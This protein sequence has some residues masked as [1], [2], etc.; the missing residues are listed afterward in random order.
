MATKGVGQNDLWQRAA[1]FAAFKHRNQIRKDGRT[2]YI[3]H[4]FRVALTARHEFGCEDPA[5]LAAAL[6]HD[7]IEDTTTDYDDL[8]SQF[9]ATVADLVAALTK[10]ASLPKDKREAQYDAQLA[11][12]DWRARLLKL[13]D[14]YDNLIDAMALG[15]DTDLIADSRDKGRRAIALAG[16][17]IAQPAMARGIAKVTAL[18]ASSS[19]REGNRARD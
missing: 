5:V 12:A 19:D 8:A 6:L 1:A 14:T 10:N 4:P 18:I 13:A 2:P 7:T 17:D 11:A 16:A 15:G 3:S 9:G